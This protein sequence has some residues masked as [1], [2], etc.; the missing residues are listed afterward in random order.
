MKIEVVFALCAILCVR[1]MLAGI[2]QSMACKCTNTE[3][4]YAST[5]NW[6]FIASVAILGHAFRWQIIKNIW[7]S[8][9]KLTS[10]IIPLSPAACVSLEICGYGA[11]PPTEQQ[12]DCW[13]WEGPLSSDQGQDEP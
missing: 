3:F 2:P 8:L 12:L 10:N 13:Y 1:A 6:A 9:Q 7:R 4:W 11:T 5:W